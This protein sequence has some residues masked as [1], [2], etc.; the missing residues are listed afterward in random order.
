MAEEEAAGIGLATVLRS[1]LSCLLPGVA[2]VLCFLGLTGTLALRDVALLLALLLVVA[3]S[4]GL[5]L[6][7]RRSAR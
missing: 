3:V 4:A 2:I 5:L 6:R 7:R 1:T